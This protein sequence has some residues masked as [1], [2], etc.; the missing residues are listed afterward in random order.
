MDVVG[1]VIT[2]MKEFNHSV[3]E[4]VFRQNGYNL[5]L[6]AVEQVAITW[7]KEYDFLPLDKAFSYGCRVDV[8]S[9]ESSINSYVMSK[10]SDQFNDRCGISFNS[11][12][13]LGCVIEGGSTLNFNNFVTIYAGQIVDIAIE[14]SWSGETLCKLLVNGIEVDS[15]AV[16]TKPTNIQQVWTVGAFSS[17]AAGTPDQLWSTVII[18]SYFVGDDKFDLSES[19]GVSVKN[20]D[21]SVVGTIQ[22]I[23]A[24]ST[25]IDAE[26]WGKK[27]FRL[28]T[29][30]S[31][32]GYLLIPNLPSITNLS[33]LTFELD[34]EFA[35]LNSSKAILTFGSNTVSE[36]VFRVATQGGNSFRFFITEPNGVNPQDVTTPATTGNHTLSLDNLVFS[37]DG[38]PSITLDEKALSITNALTPT[39]VGVLGYA[40]TVWVKDLMIYG[41]K[42]NGKVFS[43]TEGLGSEVFSDDGLS[44]GTITTNHAEGNEHINYGMW[45]KQDDN[46]DWIPYTQ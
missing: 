44:I 42:L 35:E 4:P 36:G 12:G 33:D 39:G 13:G 7:E 18:H 5:K 23:S 37:I 3:N 21:K 30:A 6:D 19:I 9:I 10:G 38:I 27:S 29:K 28:E 32:I 40:P 15:Q 1:N 17:N 43:L 34:I 45:Q 11:G 41:L 14:Y 2:P 20:L 25:Y 22:T 26:V 31:N 24:V 16:A 46:G 8:D